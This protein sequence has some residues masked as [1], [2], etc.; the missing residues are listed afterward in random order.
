VCAGADEPALLAAVV[1]AHAIGGVGS[2][3]SYPGRESVEWSLSPNRV[4][5]VQVLVV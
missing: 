5:H 2:Q 4:P 1:A 3:G